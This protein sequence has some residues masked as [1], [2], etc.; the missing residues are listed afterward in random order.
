MSIYPVL[1]KTKDQVNMRPAKPTVYDDK[2]VQCT[3]LYKNPV[4]GDD[5]SCQST[6][7]SNMWPVKPTMDMWSVEPATYKKMSSDKNCQS[8]K[9]YKKKSPVR[10]V[11][12]DKNCQ[13][14]KTMYYRKC[15]ANSA[16]TQS[17]H[18]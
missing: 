10:P 17:T 8:T 13:S 2:K 18:L 5:K 12:N 3:K 11:C 16:G 9:G 7:C 14:A 1:Q 4:C 6:L 15:Q